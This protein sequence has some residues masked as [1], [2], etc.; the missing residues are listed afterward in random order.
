[1]RA[2]VV[3]AF[4]A[5]TAG[6]APQQTFRAGVDLVHFSVIVTDKQGSPITGLTADDFELVE[7]GKPQSIS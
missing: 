4:A 1:M 2:A 6:F 5:V 7:D 3:V